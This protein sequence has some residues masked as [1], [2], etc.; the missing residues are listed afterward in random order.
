MKS[1]S[2]YAWKYRRS[3][4]PI[5]ESR[6]THYMVLY[7]EYKIFNMNSSQALFPWVQISVLKIFTHILKGIFKKT[8]F[9][10]WL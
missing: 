5:F 6:C 10:S 8:A 1:I 4:E 3:Y 2:K 9:S 7:A